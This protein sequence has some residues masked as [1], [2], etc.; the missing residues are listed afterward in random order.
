MATAEPKIALVCDW[1]TTVGG[2]EK[3]LLK[4]HQMYP[5]APIYTSQYSKKGITW[6]DDADVRTGWMQHLPS[7]MRRFFAPLRA[8][9][10]KHLDLSGYDLIISVTGAEAKGVKKGNATHLCYCHVPTQ[11]YWQMYDDYI[12]NPGFGILN[13]L[14]R[15]G[16][17]IL[18]KPLRKADFNAALKPDKFIT[19]STYAAHQIR[20]YYTRESIIIHPPVSVKSFADH[21]A[22]KSQTK[23]HN[24][25][26]KSQA[27][28]I[29]SS[30]ENSDSETRTKPYI[31]TSRQVTWKHHNIAIKA[32]LTLNRPL[33]II[34]DGPE[35]KNLVKLANNSPLISFFPTMEQPELKNHLKKARAFLFPSLEPFGI[36][37]VE[38]LAAGCPVIAYEQGGSED[39]IKDGENGVFFAKQS[40]R[41]LIDAIKRFEKLEERLDKAKIATSALPFSEENFEKA[42]KKEVKNAQKSI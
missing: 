26:A 1:L 25:S 9:Y 20:H 42:I 30:V 41:S 12:K 13:P 39:F 10:F 28:V 22:G 21:K 15:F 37:P 32:C 3:V 29:H 19:I 27:E 14:M 4:L 7:S 36:A 31:I 40:T 23:E 2:A 34:G 35:H 5:K 18:V 16:L 24:K 6:F 8:N 11:Y 17:K 33:V 38:A